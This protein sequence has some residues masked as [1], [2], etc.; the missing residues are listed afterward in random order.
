MNSGRILLQSVYI[1]ENLSWLLFCEYSLYVKHCTEGF[2]CVCS[3]FF[4]KETTMK[5]MNHDL[6]YKDEEAQAF[7]NKVIYLW[8][9]FRGGDN[10][11]APTALV[12]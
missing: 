3:F 12:L 2:R 1:E 9:V 5:C 8:W 10:R 7:S 6:L 4:R 11:V